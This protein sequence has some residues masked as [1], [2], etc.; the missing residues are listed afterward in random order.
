M[1]IT[2]AG[3]SAES[4]ISTF[5]DAGGTWEN[6]K[7][8]EVCDITTFEKNYIKV[9]D[10]YDTRRKQLA[11]VEPNAAHLKIAELSKQFDV[12]NYTTNVDDLLER[13]GCENVRHIHGNLL[14]VI[15]NYGEDNA[16]VV[17]VG[18][19]GSGYEDL[20]K[21]P[22]KPNVVFFGENAP[23]Y[24]NYQSAMWNLDCHDTI[25]IVGSSEQ[26]VPFA[27]MARYGSNFEGRI[28]FVNKDADLCMNEQ[29]NHNVQP[30]NTTAT[31]FF[32]TF[33][34]EKLRNPDYE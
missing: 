2:G 5:R 11:N 29:I 27:A 33:D 24:E 13:A 6:F 19:G 18:H 1:F 14:E 12:L 31:N 7:I 30:F 26:V 15:H 21:Y 8:E 17:N 4:G 20:T 10:F 22:V 28:I 23:M 32:E 16:E 3:L 34:F 25:I 9:N